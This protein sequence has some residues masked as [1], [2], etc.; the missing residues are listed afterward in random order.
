MLLKTHLAA[1]VFMILLFINHINHRFIFVGMA[2]F[3]TIFPDADSG[4]SLFGKSLILKPIQFFIKHR[5]I[6]HSFTIAILVSVL[7]AVFMPIASFGFF[8]GYSTHLIFDSFTKDG[9][10]PFWPHKSVSKGII[11]TGGK[12]EKTLFAFLIFID[13]ALFLFVSNF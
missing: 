10:R 5:G 9:I 8:I 4:F 7:L 11:L 6:I 3:A 12:F 13:I 2:L 1:A